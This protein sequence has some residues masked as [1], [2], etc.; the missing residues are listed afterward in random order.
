MRLSVTYTKKIFTKYLNLL[1][2]LFIQIRM[3]LLKRIVRI[4]MLKPMFAYQGGKTKA[5]NIKMV[6]NV[7]RTTRNSVEGYLIGEKL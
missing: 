6:Y 1:H 5:T 4:N 3:C 2:I 7:K